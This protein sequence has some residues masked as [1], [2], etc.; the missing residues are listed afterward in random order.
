MKKKES[1]K[2]QNLF[3]YK[4]LPAYNIDEEL[5]YSSC[6]FLTTGTIV[7]I[8]IKN[9]EAYG[10]LLSIIDKPNNVKF[11]I[12][13]IS[14]CPEETKI[15]KKIIKFIYWFAM[16]NLVNKGSVLK[17]FLPNKNIINPK[18][19]KFIKI[20]CSKKLISFSKKILKSF[21]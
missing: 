11:S 15:D 6:K 2:K 1:N 14:Y 12:K 9:K 20:N 13:S 5:V 3:Y 18:K 4:V 17:Q 21:I 10:C 7:K 19:E 16:Y 8:N